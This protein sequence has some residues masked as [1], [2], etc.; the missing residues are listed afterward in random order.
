MNGAIAIE[1]L[2][3]VVPVFN[4]WVS[5]SYLLRDL[6]RVAGELP[7]RISV[8]FVDDGSTDTPTIADVAAIHHLESVEIIHLSVNLGHQRAIAV[9]LCVAVEDGDGDAVLVMDA[10]GEDPP[11]VIETL[12]AAADSKRDFCIVVE[13]RKRSENLSF[14][15]SYLTYKVLFKILTGAQINFGNF[16]VFSRSYAQ[17]LVRIPDLWNNLPAAVLHSRLPIQFIPAD[18]AKRYAG[19]SKMNF[20]SL[21]V[22]GMR[23]ISVYADT[24][25]VRMLLLTMGVAT[26]AGILIALVLTLRLFFPVH[27]TPGWAT[28]VS[29]GMIIIL[30]QIFSVTLSSVLMLLNSRVQKLIVPIADYP[31]YVEWREPIAGAAHG[32]VP[33]DVGTVPQPRGGGA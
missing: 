18:R 15:L 8:S 27:A 7:V 5:C 10:D 23:G 2:R 11:Q 13:R 17:R 24:I 16:S 30:V 20:T 4:D 33:G 19:K 3:L 21:V 26:L 6:D 29:F 1:K 14:R 32:A 22:H 12:L 25:F 31:A 9:G 28:T